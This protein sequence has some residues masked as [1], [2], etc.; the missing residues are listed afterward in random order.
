MQQGS[1]YADPHK[2]LG[3]RIQPRQG[4]GGSHDVCQ[5]GCLVHLHTVDGWARPAI[6]M[7]DGDLQAVAVAEDEGAGGRQKGGW[8]KV[9]LTRW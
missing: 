7:H 9:G 4:G 3:G 2:L 1:G 6:A 8:G 5:R